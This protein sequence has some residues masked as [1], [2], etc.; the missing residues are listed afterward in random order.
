M[1]RSK[2]ALHNNIME[3]VG[4]RG[5]IPQQNS[6]YENTSKG[7]DKVFSKINMKA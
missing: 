1:R 5:D 6:Y 4:A 7:D 3:G 2:K